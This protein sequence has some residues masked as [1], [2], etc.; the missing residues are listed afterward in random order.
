ML[1]ALKELVDDEQWWLSTHDWPVSKVV[2]QLPD[3]DPALIAELQKARDKL[4]RRCRRAIRE[5][6]ADAAATAAP[7]VALDASLVLRREH[8][9]R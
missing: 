8:A 9:T 1:A 6:V 5:E 7:N 2:P 4:D 3:P